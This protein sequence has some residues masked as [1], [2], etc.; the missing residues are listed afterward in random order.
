MSQEEEEILVY[1]PQ[2]PE[3]IFGKWSIRN[4]PLVQA[5]D[6]AARVKRVTILIAGARYNIYGR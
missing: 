4:L 2:E 3:V 5:E 1:D 6:S